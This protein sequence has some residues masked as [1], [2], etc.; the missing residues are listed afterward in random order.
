M[1]IS[2]SFRH[3]FGGYE[4]RYQ[5]L[6]PRAPS[7]NSVSRNMRFQHQLLRLTVKPMPAS[8]RDADQCHKGYTHTTL[9]LIVADVFAKYYKIGSKIIHTFNEFIT[10]L[11]HYR[12]RRHR[13]QHLHFVIPQ[14][15]DSWH[16]IC[17]VLVNCDA[18]IG[19]I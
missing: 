12:D 16:W 14:V 3:W 8:R 19:V 5:V 2:S 15:Q 11:K 6:V 9:V 7:Q 4:S 17:I 18:G 10:W 13:F 1:N